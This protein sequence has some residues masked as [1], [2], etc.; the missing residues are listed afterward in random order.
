VEIRD[1]LPSA[2]A[3]F[4]GVFSVLVSNVFIDNREKR[5]ARAERAQVMRNYAHAL[6]EWHLYH[7]SRLGP[8]AGDHP[9]PSDERLTESARQFYP[10]LHEF[11]G[12]K[13]YGNLMSP[14]REYVPGEPPWEDSDFY[15]NA[16]NA[17][18]EHLKKNPKRAP[19]KSYRKKKT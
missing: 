8:G 18:E 12:H 10:Y 1:W 13:E 17:L 5:K 16:C 4:V 2:V 14:Y 7:Y 19:R 6:L 3:L 15:Q 9:Q 11:E